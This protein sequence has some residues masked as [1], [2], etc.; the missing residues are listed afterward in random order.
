[1]VVL[2]PPQ[3]QK[4]YHSNHE[5]YGLYQDRGERFLEKIEKQEPFELTDGSSS[6][7]FKNSPG[8]KSLMGKNYNELS[9]GKKLFIKE[10]GELISLSNFIKTEEFGSSKGQ[11]AGSKNTALQESSQCVFNAMLRSLKKT[12]L[13]VEDVTMENISSSYQYCDT[14]TPW[15]DIYEFSQNKAWQQSFLT[16]S[17]LLSQ[18]LGEMEYENHRDSLF[19]DSIYGAYHENQ[20]EYQSDK[21]NPADIWLVK[22]SALST[23]FS[24]SLDD[25]N[26]QVKDMFEKKELIGVSLKKTGKDAKIEV[27]NLDPSKKKT[28]IYEGYKTT[29][30]SKDVTLLYNE[31]KICFRTFTYGASWA[32][33]ILGKTASH[34]K[35]GIKPLNR[36]LRNNGLLPLR[37]P[38]VIKEAWE[39]PKCDIENVKTL[40]SFLISDYIGGWGENFNIFIR[41]K[42]FDWKVSKTM[43][44]ILLNIIE[45]QP[46]EIKNKIITDI[47]LYASSESEES[48]VFLKIS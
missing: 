11:G 44:L 46:Q 43:G 34:G 36:I 25:L 6:I 28:Y 9:G 30:K 32:G 47:I 26:N 15:E 3:L 27:K 12:Y 45:S 1:M 38:K 2:S 10:D 8:V 40:L 35:I 19:I 24:S 31:G 42:S 23:V 33:E 13:D 20:L 5:L 21:W 18:Y 41:D 14:T 4:P 17:N 39:N 37:Y 16:S 22:E 29:S 48:S 7:I